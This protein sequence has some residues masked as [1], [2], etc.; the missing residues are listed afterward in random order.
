MSVSWPTLIA[1]ADGYRE[2]AWSWADL[3]RDCAPSDMRAPLPALG[4]GALDFLEGLGRSLPRSS[5]PEALDSLDGQCANALPKWAHPGAI[6]SGARSVRPYPRL[7]MWKSEAN[8]TAPT[9]PARHQRPVV[10][11]TCVATAMP[12][13][14]SV[15]TAVHHQFLRRSATSR[16]IHISRTR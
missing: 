3:L 12:A 4:D 8:Q 7:I 15:E 13:K 1:T 5:A 16:R 9:T 6:R 2:S 14:G 10:A 11:V